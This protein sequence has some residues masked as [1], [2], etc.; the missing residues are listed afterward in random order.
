MET[1]QLSRQAVVNIQFQVVVLLYQVW[2][3]QPI[4]MYGQLTT[5]TLSL[6]EW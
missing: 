4:K 5:V 1:N 6:L 3:N 2:I